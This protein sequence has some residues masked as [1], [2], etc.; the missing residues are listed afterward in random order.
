MLPGE[1]SEELASMLNIDQ[2]M[3]PFTHVRLTPK[4]IGMLCDYVEQVR[5]VVG[6]EIP[7]AVDHFGHIPVDDC[8]DFHRIYNCR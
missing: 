4:G 8:D 5:A 6:D 3:H 7:I 2:L 1:T